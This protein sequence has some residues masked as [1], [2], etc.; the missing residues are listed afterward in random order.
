MKEYMMRVSEETHNQIVEMAKKDFRK[1][2]QE[3]AYMIDFAYKNMHNPA[4]GIANA[5]APQKGMTPEE[6]KQ[7]PKYKELEEQ[8]AALKQEAYEIEGGSFETMEDVERMRRLS[9]ENK[10]KQVEIQNQ[11]RAMLNV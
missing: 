7:T 8:L 9:D 10:S 3:M 11:M 6:V 4:L 2:G 5:L 1:I